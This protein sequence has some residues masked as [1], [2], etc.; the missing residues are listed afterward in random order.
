MEK[1][2]KIN[3]PEGYEI[4]KE[5]STFEKI[6]FKKSDGLPM[7]WCDLKEVGGYYISSSSAVREYDPNWPLDT[8]R[9]TWPTK[10]EA[11]A[12]DEEFDGVTTE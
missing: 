12:N 2:I 1:E 3:V 7:G 11:E 6:V 4:D 8:N 9:N 5:K 10:E